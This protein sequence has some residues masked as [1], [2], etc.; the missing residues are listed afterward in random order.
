[1]ITPMSTMA[2]HDKLFKNQ[3]LLFTATRLASKSPEHKF[4][5]LYPEKRYDSDGDAYTLQSFLDFY[6]CD[7]E[8]HEAHLYPDTTDRSYSKKEVME[9]YD[10]WQEV[11]LHGYHETLNQTFLRQ[12]KEVVDTDPKL[13]LWKGAFVLPEVFYEEHNHSNCWRKPSASLCCDDIL[14]E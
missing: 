13:P 1:M 5:L 7:E 8:W 12:L 6:G 14:P 2:T 10:D 4:L 11:W 3:S 9:Q